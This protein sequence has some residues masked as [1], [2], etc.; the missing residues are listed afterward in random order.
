[1]GF[2]A[3]ARGKESACQCRKCRRRHRFDP[4][5]GKILWKRKW[6]PTPV[7]LPGKSHGPRNLAG[8]SPWGH[9]ELDSVEHNTAAYAPKIHVIYCVAVCALLHWSGT[10]VAVS[11][12]YA[13]VV[14]IHWA[15]VFIYTLR[16]T[17]GC[18]ISKKYIYIY[19]LLS[20]VQLSPAG[21][22]A[23]WTKWLFVQN[24]WLYLFFLN[25]IAFL[26]STKL[27]CILNF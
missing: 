24:I 13:C 3:G 20:F 21:V 27:N 18:T 6:H 1:M 19:I 4:S 10:K 26:M 15:C 9:K 14:Y 7:L 8:Y 5:V 11:L 2:P 25:Y 17:K 22:L 12:R 23:N 16:C